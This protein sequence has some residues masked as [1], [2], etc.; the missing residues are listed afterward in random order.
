MTPARSFF[1]D[2]LTLKV[3]KNAQNFKEKYF[4]TL[5]TLFLKKEKHFQYDKCFEYLALKGIF[6]PVIFG[7]AKCVW[8]ESTKKRKK[9][10]EI[11]QKSTFTPY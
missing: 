7:V 8:V 11:S 3:L 2:N 1:I 5:F 6:F 4:Y 10:I 9:M